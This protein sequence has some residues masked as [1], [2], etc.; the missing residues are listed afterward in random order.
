M[1]KIKI[2]AATVLVALSVGANAQFSQLE[3]KN[4]FMLKVELNYGP[5]VG[6]VGQAGNLGYYLNKYYNM[7]G[8]NL[9]VGANVS[10][11]WFI[12]GGIG[13]CYYHNNTQ[14][15]AD[16]LMGANVFLDV[17]FRPIWQ[18]LMGV[19]YQPATIKWAP[20]VG[21]RLGASL[22]LGE[23]EPL[24]YGTTITPL[25]EF[26]GG[27]NWYYLHGLRDMKHNWHS[28]YVTLGFAYMQQTVF[29]PIRL[30]WRW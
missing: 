16:P 22:L 2:I 5:F 29:M 3:S 11:D 8:G 27:I 15:L 9:M 19:D 1:N 12:G 14:N 7:A 30:G 21:G 10:Q 13:Y 26:Y 25:F 17:D 18:G 28:F 6:N 23:E 20:M 4:E 24:G